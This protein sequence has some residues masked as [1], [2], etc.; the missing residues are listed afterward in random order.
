M[1]PHRVSTPCNTNQLVRHLRTLPST[2]VYTSN[3]QHFFLCPRAK[4]LHIPQLISHLRHPGLARLPNVYHSRLGRRSAIWISTMTNKMSLQLSSWYE[5][6]GR[7]SNRSKIGCFSSGST[8]GC[9]SNRS[10]TYLH[11]LFFS[12]GILL[13]E[14]ATFRRNSKGGTIRNISNERDQIWQ[15]SN[16]I[17]GEA[18]RD[19]SNESD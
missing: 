9:F 4:V 13:D 8:S 17:N 16:K 2:S 5:S 15:I 11:R 10:T 1:Y 12:R 14:C 3:Y 18:I 19:I 7:F 6:M